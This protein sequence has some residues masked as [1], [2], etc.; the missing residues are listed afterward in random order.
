MFF[1]KCF[2]DF[3]PAFSKMDKN[4]C[5]FSERGLQTL[6]LDILK[7]LFFKYFFPRFRQ[8]T[9]IKL[10]SAQ[11]G[12]LNGPFWPSNHPILD[13]FIVLPKMPKAAQKTRKNPL[14][15]MVS[16]PLL[17]FFLLPGGKTPSR[18]ICEIRGWAHCI[19]HVRSCYRKYVGE[20]R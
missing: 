18:K 12:P 11:N 10:F 19:S 15:C 17:A 4:K 14:T 2:T 13:I 8:L 1:K 9:F 3:I 20:C 5:P 6:I 16:M 7:S